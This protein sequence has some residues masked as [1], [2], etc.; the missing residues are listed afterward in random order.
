MAKPRLLPDLRLFR[1]A[2]AVADFGGFGAAAQRLGISQPPLSQRI[3]ELEEILGTR[4][5]VRGPKGATVTAA[6]NVFLANAR[7]AIEQAE[8][9]LKRGQA[10]AQGAAGQVTIAVA[11]G[12]MFGFLPHLLR[13]F[14]AIN[15]DVQVTMRNLSPDQQMEQ[16]SDGRMDVGFTRLA[17]TMAGL[18][19]E[20][21]HREGYVAAIPRRLAKNLKSPLRLS[22]L[23]DF[24][25]VM[26]QQEGSGFYAEVLA[27]CQGAG[28]MPRVA[29]ETAPM[30]AVIG[31][32]AAE[33]GVAIVPM[34]TTRLAFKDVLYMP[35]TGLERAS[36]LYMATRKHGMPAVTQKFV[37]F[38]RQYCS[39]ISSI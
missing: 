30:H 34:S 29:Q 2:L 23:K 12:S 1:Y 18:L 26:F 31:L 17:P 20:K 11:G 39:E 22:M 19:L 25:F 15:V 6:G 8:N 36:V 10:A 3:A 37:E 7:I 16:I 24:N 38:S 28:F 32:V 9:A 27:L 5:F 14:C 4:L 13:D 21:V 35:L 33:F